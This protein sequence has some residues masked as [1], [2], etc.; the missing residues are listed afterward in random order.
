MIQVLTQPW[1]FVSPNVGLVTFPTLESKGHVT[2]ALPKRSPTQNCQDD[3]I[4]SIF[5]AHMWTFPV[6]VFFQPKKNTL[7]TSPPDSGVLFGL[8]WRG[9]GS[10]PRS[11]PPVR[12]SWMDVISS[13]KEIPRP[14]QRKR[15]VSGKKTAKKTRFLRRKPTKKSYEFGQGSRDSVFHATKW[16]M[17]GDAKVEKKILFRKKI[18]TWWFNSWPCLGFLNDL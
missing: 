6:A 11:H 16:K 14:G 7:P 9:V 4:I 18:T 15:R 17:E 13:W 1:P 8:P 5:S 10:C 3:D 12:I 2:P